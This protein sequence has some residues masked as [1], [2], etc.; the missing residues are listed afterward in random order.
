M[1][2]IAILFGRNDIYSQSIHFNWCDDTVDCLK[3]LR[4][5][6]EK[7]PI[8]GS[9]NDMERI[10]KT[11]EKLNGS[12]LTIGESDCSNV[13][14]T[15]DYVV[16]VDMDT[17]ECSCRI[18]LNSDFDESDQEE[19]YDASKETLNFDSLAPMEIEKAIRFITK[20]PIFVIDKEVYKSFILD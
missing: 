5:V 3:T 7:M 4:E 14:E 20:H 8:S 19:A 13:E 1:E 12:F 16:Y 15:S 2:R 17:M 9:I 10:E 18:F 6:F 11:H